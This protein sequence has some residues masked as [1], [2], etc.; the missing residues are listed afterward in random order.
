MVTLDDKLCFTLY[1][2]GL[3]PGLVYTYLL[4]V[5]YYRAVGESLLSVL[6]YAG[7]MV[8]HVICVYIRSSTEPHFILVC[9]IIAH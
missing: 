9:D 6:T 3:V 4:D 5:G 7:Q 2:I 8:V 1:Q